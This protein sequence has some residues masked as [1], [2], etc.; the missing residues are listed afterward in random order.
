MGSYGKITQGASSTPAST[1][2]QSAATGTGNGTNLNVQGYASATVQISGTFSAT[3]TFEISTDDSVWTAIPARPVG[4]GAAVSTT[5]TA[6]GVF[7]FNTAGFKSLRARISTYASG[8][9]TAVGTTSVVSPI[10]T[11]EITIKGITPDVGN[12][13]VGSATQRVTLASDGTGQVTLASGSN[14]IGALTANQSVNLSQIAATTTATG[15]GTA[16]AG[17]QRVTIA[18]DNTA[19]TTNSAQSGTWNINNVSGTISLPTG[20]ATSAKQPALG[21]A[22]SASTDVITVQGISSMTALKVDGSAVTQPVSGTV[23]ANAGTNLNT[24]ALALESGGNLATVASGV[25]SQGAATSGQKAHLIQGAV[26]TSAPTYT[27]GNSNPLSLTTGGALRVDGSGSTVT[28]NAGTNLNTSALA[29]ES[30]GNLATLAGTAVAQTSVTSGQSGYLMQGAVTTTAP[31]YTTGRTNPL[32]LNNAGG[33]R[34]DGSAVTQPISGTITANAG[35]NLNTSAL[36]LE[37]GGNL[38]TVAGLS[39]AQAST[40]SGQKGILVQGAV[41]TSIPTYTTAQT[42]PISLTTLGTVRTDLSSIAGSV[43]VSG[44]GTNTGALRVTIAS[45]CTGQIA[46]AAGSNIIGALTANQSVNTAQ[47][48]GTTTATG[49]GT[50][51][52]G[53]QR[54][55]IAS[56]NTAFTVNAIQSGTWNTP[57][58]ATSNV[59]SVANAVTS[60]QILASNT[61]RKGAYFYNDSTTTVYL[62]LGTTASTSSFT[63]LIQPSG[64]YELAQPC[65][66]GRIDAIATAA[67][68]NLRVTEIQ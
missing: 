22:G 54:V 23:T 36:A 65:Y 63:I 68:G 33:L 48:A 14:T 58:Y 51:S 13:T 66:N 3:I 9:V 40:T 1:T 45:D 16:S 28:A 53:C 47:I 24:S 42:S 46:L 37:S 41:T 6:A 38:A 30:G 29:L 35:T 56:D 43:A 8:S 50:A 61:S 2:M 26:T 25:L 18:S 34:V 39:L 4:T 55:T 49:N 12:G 20:A 11:N 64:Y 15:N 32:S 67:T 19:F 62:K 52:A 31:S 10:G 21:T 59:T 60:T 17:C 5:A 44:N 57:S 7:C 27:T